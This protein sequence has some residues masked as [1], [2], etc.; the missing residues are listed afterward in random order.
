MERAKLVSDNGPLSQPI[1]GAR[2][3]TRGDEMTTEFLINATIRNIERDRLPE[4]RK[5]MDM[6]EDGEITAEQLKALHDLM[7][8]ACWKHVMD[9]PYTPNET[10]LSVL[11]LPSNW[12]PPDPV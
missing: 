5:C 1:S 10:T 11:G 7:A 8:W 4:A 12:Q 9:S 2:R 3:E 6:F